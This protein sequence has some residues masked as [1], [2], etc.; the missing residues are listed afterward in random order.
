MSG[1]KIL[2]AA[3]TGVLLAASPAAADKHVR[4]SFDCTKAA[5]PV[6]KAICGDELLAEL[7]QSVDALYRAIR[8]AAAPEPRRRIEDEQR[9][10]LAARDTRCA[11]DKAIAECLDRLYR[12]RSIGLARAGHASGA[13]AGALIGGDYVMRE[14]GLSGTMFIAEKPPNGAFVMIDTVATNRPST[15]QCGLGDLAER[16]GDTL[17]IKHSERK[18]N[19]LIRI[20]IAGRRATIGT[21]PDGCH[22]GIFEACGMGATIEGYYSRQ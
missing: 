19:C 16:R 14:R 2:G 20:A 6:E 4:P 21:V 3:L 13:L 22:E 10:W 9:R 12:Q 17:F 18:P 11:R 1:A 8:T 15:P 7:D 5:T